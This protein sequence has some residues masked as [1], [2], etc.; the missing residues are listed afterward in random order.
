MNEVL[1]EVLAIIKAQASV[2]AMT[3]EEITSMTSSLYTNLVALDNGT[4]VA[5]AAQEPAVDPAKSIR[6]KSI[7]CLEC[8]KSFKVLTKKHLVKHDLTPEAYKEKWGLKPKC[9]LVAKGLARD[10]KKKMLEMELWK[11]RKPHAT[12]S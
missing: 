6:E 7:V 11:K 8:G 4:P 12:K 1:Q 2:R 10:R 3:P 9:S 5:G